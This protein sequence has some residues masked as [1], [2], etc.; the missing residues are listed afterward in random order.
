MESEVLREFY[1]DIFEAMA[2]I[3]HPMWVASLLHKEGMVPDE[4]LGVMLDSTKPYSVKNAAIMRAISTVV[5]A[6]PKK[7][8]VLMT[9][10]E[11]FPESAPV[12]RRM[13]DAL[14][15]HELGER[16]RTDVP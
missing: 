9:V 8:L 5:R 15:S 6:D 10:L 16:S 2:S 4:V 11:R 3:A 12:A 14:R 7:L 1:S 13:R